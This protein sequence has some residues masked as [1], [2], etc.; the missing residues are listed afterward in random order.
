MASEQIMKGLQTRISID[1]RRPDRLDE[2]EEPKKAHDVES[3]PLPSL[4]G[5]PVAIMSTDASPKG[6]VTI[7]AFRQVY[8]NKKLVW[9]FWIAMLLWA[10]AMALSQDTTFVCESI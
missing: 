10:F 5:N 7:S 6:V 1:A 9:V 4:A 2:E 3:L 8:S